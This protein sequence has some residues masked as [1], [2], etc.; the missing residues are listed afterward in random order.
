MDT[1]GLLMMLLGSPKDGFSSCQDN[2]THKR[3]GYCYCAV[4]QKYCYCASA[5]IQATEDELK[6]AG[7]RRSTFASTQSMYE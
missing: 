4:R 2:I 7:V 3:Q 1:V 5:A 6:D